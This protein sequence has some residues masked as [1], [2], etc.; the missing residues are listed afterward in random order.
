MMHSG[1]CKE[2][3]GP[4]ERIPEKVVLPDRCAVMKGERARI[5]ACCLESGDFFIDIVGFAW[6]GTRAVVSYWQ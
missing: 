6:V 5:R 1:S 4:K 3:S 2:V